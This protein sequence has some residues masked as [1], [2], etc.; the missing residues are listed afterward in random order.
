MVG[1][2]RPISR[3]PF[4]RCPAR[5]PVKRRDSSTGE[6][7]LRVSGLGG[8]ANGVVVSPIGA[9]PGDRQPVNISRGRSGS[10]EP[11][12]HE[13]CGR[14]EELMF[15]RFGDFGASRIQS[16]DGPAITFHF[17][18][19]EPAEIVKWTWQSRLPLTVIG[20]ICRN[21]SCITRPPGAWAAACPADSCG[22]FRTKPGTP[23]RRNWMSRPLPKRPLYP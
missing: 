14:I 9:H 11:H 3:F 16:E 8:D 1:A 4:R 22:A 13:W 19:R 18:E 20:P 23:A 2:W 7:A 6:I 10:N 15:D 17:L 12:R 21:G 5:K